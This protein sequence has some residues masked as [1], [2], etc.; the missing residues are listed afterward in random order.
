MRANAFGAAIVALLAVLASAPSARA[1]GR[2]D[3][4]ASFRRG[5]S[6][7]EAGDYAGAR[8]AFLEAYRLFAHPSI[9][10]NLGIARWR[11]GENVAGE[12]ALA[13]F[14]SDDGGAS[15]AEIAS[16]R[17]A[18]SQTRDHLGTLHVR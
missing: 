9:L 1:D 2:E 16:A 11:T 7:A 10:L 14:L 5:V 4:R 6:A 3:S 13:K 12:E 8:D 15:Q 18:L 17:A